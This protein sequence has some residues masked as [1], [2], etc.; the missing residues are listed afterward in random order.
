MVRL[1]MFRKLLIAA[2][3]TLLFVAGVAAQDYDIVPG[4]RIGKIEIGMSRQAVHSTLGQPGGV[5]RMRARGYRGEY[6]T[7]SSDNTLRVIYDVAGRVYQVSV[8]STR[9]TTS[10]GLTTQSSLSDIKSHYKNLKALHF[11]A[12]ADID[13]YDAIRQGIAFE[14]TQ[15]YDAHSSQAMR[16]YAILIHK[17]GSSVMPEPDE[18]VRQ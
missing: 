13:Y 11:T 8:T 6:W 3:L 16:L 10:E 14:F 9:F 18:R 5:Y 7:S 17:S 2:C 15:R 4:S 1:K 12:R